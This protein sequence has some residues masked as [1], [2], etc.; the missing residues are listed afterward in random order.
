MKKETSNQLKIFYYFIISRRL[1]DFD[2]RFVLMLARS[3]FSENNYQIRYVLLHTKML[4][5]KLK[6]RVFLPL[7]PPPTIEPIIK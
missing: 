1:I 3:E 2:A 4:F 6:M 5:R 7:P